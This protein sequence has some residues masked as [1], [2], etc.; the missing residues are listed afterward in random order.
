M[1]MMLSFGS[2]FPISGFVS[3]PRLEPWSVA[4]VQKLIDVVRLV[5]A[6]M[7]RLVV[8][9]ALLRQEPTETTWWFPT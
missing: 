2:S 4:I 6:C 7:R 1:L 8:R 3:K 5:P 9:L